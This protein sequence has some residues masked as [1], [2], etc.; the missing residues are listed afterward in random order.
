MRRRL[1]RLVVSGML[2]ISMMASSAFA[3]VIEP[4]TSSIQ[5]KQDETSFSFE[6]SLTTEEDFAGAEFGLKPSSSDIKLSS[7]AMLGDFADASKV[8]TTKDGVLYFGFFSSSNKFEQ[9]THTVARVTGTYTGTGNRTIELVSSKVVTID[10]SKQTHGDT[11]SDAFAVKVS[12]AESEKPSGGGGGG[13]GG[14]NT[15]PVQPSKPNENT[16]GVERLP[17]TD[18]AKS[19]YY[20]SAVKWAVGKGITSGTSA[21]TFSPD[22]SCT[23]AQMVTFLWRTAGSP[24]P[25]ISTSPFADIQPGTYYYNAV[26]WALEKGITSGTSTDTFSPD[27]VVTRGQTVTFLYRAS[28]SPTVSGGGFSDVPED[29]Y[30]AAAVKW[31]LEKGITSGVGDG[32]FAPND[33]CTRAQIV[34]FLYR[35]YNTG[36]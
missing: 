25:T 5:L 18:V 27:V 20:Y 16:G 19:D 12:R 10:E 6:I 4:S 34:T 2:A 21:T 11:S 8:Q 35:A 7:V 23:R 30:Y 32:L 1:V 13:G 31:A 9:G 14:G 36:S 3:T 17:F 15:S 33:E 28:G 24:E 22:L 29:A 26:L